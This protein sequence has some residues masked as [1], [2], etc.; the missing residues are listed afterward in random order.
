MIVVLRPSSEIAIPFKGC[1]RCTVSQQPGG[2][3]ISSAR[4]PAAPHETETKK[5]LMDFGPMF[6]C[7]ERREGARRWI[8]SESL[9]GILVT[10]GRRETQVQYANSQYTHTG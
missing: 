10:N 9:R 3:I 8:K 1:A 2:F 7:A 6:G 5:R 4:L